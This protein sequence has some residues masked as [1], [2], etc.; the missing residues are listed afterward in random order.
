MK[1]SVIRSTLLCVLCS[2]SIVA[3]GAT[4]E[5]LEKKIESL[6]QRLTA[7]E[8]QPAS[9]EANNKNLFTLFR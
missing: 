1:I 5:E 8:E 9:Q 2:Q 4:E 7:I 3:Y 6:E